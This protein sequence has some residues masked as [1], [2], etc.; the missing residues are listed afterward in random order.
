MPDV[1]TDHERAAIEAFPSDRIQRIPR[2][3]SGE[4]ETWNPGNWRKRHV[5]AKA[6]FF[7]ERAFVAL[8]A[9]EEAP[10]VAPAPTTRQVQHAAMAVRQAEVRRLIL[11]GLNHPAIAAKLGVHVATVG[12]DV[13]AMR[14]AGGFP[15]VRECVRLRL[16]LA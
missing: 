5:I 13:A 8:K 10:V 12:A 16:G 9:R 3:V 11:E 7:R 15:T 6:R 14:K 2:G 4:V 1:I